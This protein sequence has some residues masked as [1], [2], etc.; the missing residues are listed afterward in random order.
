MNVK[1]IGTIKVTTN[2]FQTRLPEYNLTCLRK[3]LEHNI[4]YLNQSEVVKLR[5][6]IRD[7]TE[8]M[9]LNIKL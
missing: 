5:K 3:Q 8:L 7:P 2:S 1:I 9:D 6:I 4:I